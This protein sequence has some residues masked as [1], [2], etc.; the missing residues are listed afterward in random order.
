MTHSLVHAVNQGSYTRIVQMALI[1]HIQCSKVG[2]KTGSVSMLW[3]TCGYAV[4]N[5]SLKNQ[6]VTK[7]L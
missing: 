5:F 2:S 1:A 3:I 7:S 4:D 6:R